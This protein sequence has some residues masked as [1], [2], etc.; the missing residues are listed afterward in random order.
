MK[1][2]LPPGTK[3]PKIPAEKVVRDRQPPPSRMVISSDVHMGAQDDYV[4]N[5]KIA[6]MRDFK[7]DCYIENGDLYDFWSIS[8]FDKEPEKWLDIGG[9]LQ[10]E[11]DV[12]SDHWQE[13]CNISKRVEYILGNHEDRL[14]RLVK[15]NQGLFKLRALNWHTLA[16][17]PQRVKIH[18]YGT[19]I[20]IGPVGIEHG[21]KIGGAGAKYRAEWALSNRVGENTV[22]GHWHL[23]Q[24][25][26]KTVLGKVYF[27]HGLGHQSDLK[28]Q[29]Y[30]SN[31]NWTHGFAAIEFWYY[32]NVL[33]FTFHPI[34]IVNNCFSFGGTMYNGRKWQ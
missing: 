9:R 34:T 24:T 14:N 26:H 32:G 7:P 10:E 22:F 31:P 17:I 20:K 21:D 4:L 19:R 1:L 2:I 29:K 33:N 18:P 13:V 3:P 15:A 8:R 6:F 5:A 12:A 23:S 27:A 11:F 28:K 16:G 30:A 25:M